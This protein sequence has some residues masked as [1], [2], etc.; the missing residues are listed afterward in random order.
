MIIDKEFVCAIT[1]AL[2]RHLVFIII[3]K[4][5]KSDKRHRGIPLYVEHV[6]RTRKRYRGGRGNIARTYLLATGVEERGKGGFIRL[7]RRRVATRVC[8]SPPS[9][10]HRQLLPRTRVRSPQSS[11]NDD[12]I[13]F[14]CDCAAPL[15]TFYKRYMVMCVESR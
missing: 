4:K 14:A 8:P 9:H 7:L 2:A 6:T 1:A 5:K 10:Y 15:S 13:S 3:K 11:L 12:C